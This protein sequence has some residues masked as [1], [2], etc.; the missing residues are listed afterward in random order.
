MPLF[1][2]RIILELYLNSIITSTIHAM[3][4][5]RAVRPITKPIRSDM[6][7]YSSTMP[8]GIDQMTVSIPLPI[9]WRMDIYVS[10]IDGFEVWYETGDTIHDGLHLDGA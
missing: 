6:C 1:H 10:R 5:A 7:S 3:N 8:F 2:F 9:E 4:S